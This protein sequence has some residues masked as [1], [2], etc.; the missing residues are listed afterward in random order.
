MSSLSPRRKIDARVK[1]HYEKA[2]EVVRK[3]CEKEFL[4]F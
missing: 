3:E 1:F 4:K 2:T